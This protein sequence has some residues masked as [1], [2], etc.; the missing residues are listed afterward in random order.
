MSNDR[1]FYDRDAQNVL[2]KQGCEIDLLAKENARIDHTL[3]LSYGS[4]SVAVDVNN[5]NKLKCLL[6]A[7]DDYDKLAAV[8]TT[9]CKEL[10]LKIAALQQKVAEN[11]REVK[12]EEA[13]HS[14]LVE[15]NRRFHRIENKVSKLTTDFCSLLKEND[16]MRDKIR[17]LVKE[18][19]IYQDLYG[20]VTSRI[21]NY[22]KKIMHITKEASGHYEQRLEA[23]AKMKT[24]KERSRKDE[25]MFQ[26]EMKVL[27]R[28]IAHDSK[29]KAFVSSKENERLA[30]KAEE[31]E[32]RAE[33]SV[34]EKALNEESS[35]VQKFEEL[36]NSL[37][38]VTGHND[39]ENV[40]QDFTTKD[41]DNFAKFDYVSELNH[42]VERLRES[43]QTIKNNIKVMNDEEKKAKS[44]SE[45][46]INDLKAARLQLEEILMM[47]EEKQ[48]K[49]NG[50]IEDVCAVV[51]L[52]FKRISCST[53][54]FKYALAFDEHVS[55]EN[56]KAYLSMIEQR[57]ME[58]ICILKFIGLHQDHQNNLL[59]SPRSLHRIRP[60]G[61]SKMLL[62]L[63]D[64]PIMPTISTPNISDDVVD[65]ML[66]TEDVS[67][68]LDVSQ[69]REK[70][71]ARIAKQE[72]AGLL[73][74][75]V[76]T[77]DKRAKAN[78]ARKK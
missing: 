29:M 41:E 55:G 1:K 66:D 36:F 64:K 20:R 50:T 5:T 31:A 19:T 25:T 21:A 3:M 70:A 30:Y 40:V 46:E 28:M 37:R 65:A 14:R 22:K 27:Q 68:P 17:L 73:N 11:Q 6:A 76:Y 59:K 69:L 10:D 32:K 71:M 52:L 74:Q 47:E 51:H 9:L 8:E 38:N 57:C 2:R 33:M 16:E 7:R 58:L 53:D 78:K 63:V 23:V 49:L 35:N 75:S 4:R 62:E 67:A 43:I 45:E 15:S 18:K 44:G 39:L 24:L 60:R 72:A 77:Q 34:K 13:E 26:S 48:T 54:T 61:P 56:V 42:D 12:G